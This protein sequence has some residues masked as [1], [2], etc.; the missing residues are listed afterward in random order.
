MDASCAIEQVREKARYR[1]RACVP[2]HDGHATGDPEAAGRGLDGRGDRDDLQ[3]ARGSY[4]LSTGGEGG[5]ARGGRERFEGNRRHRT[6]HRTR[7]E[8]LPP[9]PLRKSPSH[10]QNLTRRLR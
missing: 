8:E 5:E 9:P 3:Y 1:L 2:R 6:H 7:A 10:L 4:R